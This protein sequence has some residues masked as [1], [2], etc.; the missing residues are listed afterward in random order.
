MRIIEKGNLQETTIKCEECGSVLAYTKKDVKTI[1][2]MRFT[3]LVDFKAVVC[4]VCREYILIER[5]F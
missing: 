4:P 5:V 1:S 3:D 2:L